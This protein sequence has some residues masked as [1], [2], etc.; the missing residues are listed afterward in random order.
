MRDRR[1]LVTG[2]VVL[3]WMLVITGRRH[4]LAVEE[5]ILVE[6]EVEELT[7]AEEEWLR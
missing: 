5:R 6:A 4:H 3:L 1:C 2:L 7:L